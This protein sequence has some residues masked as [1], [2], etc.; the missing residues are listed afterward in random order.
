MDIREADLDD[1]SVRDLV[2]SHQQR[3]FENSPPGTSFA[4]DLSGLR[5]PEITLYAAWDGNVLLGIG[6]LME[7]AGDAG[8]VKSMRTTDASLRRGVGSAI[9]LHIESEARRRGY[10]RLLLETGTGE[11][12]R[13][14]NAM[15]RK[16]G[17]IRRGPFGD[18]TETGFNIFYEKTF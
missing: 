18:Y 17:Y 3:A 9:L 16:Q 1:P 6:A 14:A 11:A 5:R 7:V 4:L 8:E 10:A 2:T 12:Y 15:Y 13:P